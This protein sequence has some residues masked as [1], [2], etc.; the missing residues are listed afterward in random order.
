LTKRRTAALSL[1][2]ARELA[3]RRAGAFLVVCPGVQ[4]EAHLEA[5][6]EGFSLT[7]V[8]VRG[9]GRERV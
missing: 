9:R 3:P 8:L 7:R 6:A 2:A 5:F 4:G 1:L